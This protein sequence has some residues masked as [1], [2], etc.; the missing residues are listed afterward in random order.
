LH[1]NSKNDF[2]SFRC[3]GEIVINFPPLDKWANR[4]GQS[5]LGT[6]FT[7]HN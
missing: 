3:E 5:N 4:T 7:M 1:P 6:I 2:L